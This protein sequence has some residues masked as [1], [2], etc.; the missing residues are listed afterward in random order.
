MLLNIVLL[1][2]AFASWIA[3]FA[4]KKLA[5]E[6][7]RSFFQRVSWQGWLA[8]A[9]ATGALSLGVYK[10]VL[11]N[12][13]A[14]K[15]SMEKAH[16]Q[17]SL[18]AALTSN[19]SLRTHLSAGL[20]SMQVLQ[21]RLGEGAEVLIDNTCNG[22]A[23]AFRLSAAIP[24]ESDDCVV[25]LN[26]DPTVR[27]S[28]RRGWMELYW[29][30]LFEYSMF[31]PNGTAPNGI[32]LKVGGRTYP[33]NEQHGTIRIYGLNPKAMTAELLNPN[34]LEGVI[35]KSF[36][37]TTDS[38]Q[39]QQEFRKLVLQGQ[40]AAFAKRTY[41]V[42]RADVARVTSDANAKSTVRSQLTRGSFV[43][44]LQPQGDWTEVMTPE[45]RQ[46]WVPAEQLG[47]IE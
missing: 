1:A 9:C 17:N 45:G 23:D 22:L 29:G 2:L 39:G 20:D 33:L 42:V 41:K 6:T 35:L 32:A 34:R 14:A 21:Q 26:G 19:D 4:G 31:M 10:E 38:N 44:V 28:G 11:A 13:S 25:H 36:I 18:Q 24:R 46:G 15:S 7:E 3:G 8:A 47:P 30:D 12:E 5:D 16:L 43:R 40:C 27:I 37:K